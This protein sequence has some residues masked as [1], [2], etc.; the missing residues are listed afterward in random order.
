MPDVQTQELWVALAGPAVNVIVAGAISSGCRH[1]EAGEPLNR[2]NVAS[3]AF[4]ERILMANVFLAGF[5]LLPAFP[6]DGGRVLRALL[7]TRMDTREPPSVQRRLV[8][9]WRFY[10]LSSVSKVIRC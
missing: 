1:R 7:A 2:V 5:N 9:A 10:S 4:A 3:G 8:K 6:M